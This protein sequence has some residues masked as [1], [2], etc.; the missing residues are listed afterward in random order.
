MRKQKNNDGFI[1]NSLSNRG[2][3]MKLFKSM[4]VL[5]ASLLG[6]AAWSR[7]VTAVI[8]LSENIP[9]AELARQVTDP[10]SPRFQKFYTP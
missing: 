3:V 8:R 4:M 1:K 2:G 5:T 10:Q 7:P 9:M 6:S